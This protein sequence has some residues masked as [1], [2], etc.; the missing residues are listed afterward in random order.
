MYHYHVSNFS[1]NREKRQRELL[2]V[3][4][5]NQSI[6]HRIL[7]RRPQYHREVWQK[8][9]QRN[10]K[11]MDSISAF[12]P[13]WWEKVIPTFSTEPLDPKHCETL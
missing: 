1:L 9:W 6:I 12:A 4:K 10:L 3:T 11:Y 5:E 13:N 2:R 7:S 8:D